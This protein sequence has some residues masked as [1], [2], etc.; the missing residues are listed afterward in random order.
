MNQFNVCQLCRFKKGSHV[1]QIKLSY[2]DDVQY[3]SLT[4]IL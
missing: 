2:F 1:F 3:L 4:K